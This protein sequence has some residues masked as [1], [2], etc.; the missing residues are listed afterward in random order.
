MDGYELGIKLSLL[1]GLELEIELGTLKGSR[2]GPL[3]G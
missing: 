1:L 2:L 3:D